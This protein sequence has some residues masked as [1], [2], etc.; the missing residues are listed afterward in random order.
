VIEDLIKTPLFRK[1]FPPV[2]GLIFVAVFVSLGLWQLDRAAQK[3]ALLALFDGGAPYARVSDYGSL[4]RFDRIEVSGHYLT[5]RQILIDNIVQ[6]GRQGYFVITP[7][8]PDSGQPLLLVNRGWTGKVAGAPPMIDVGQESRTLRGL[9]GQ[10]PRVGIRPGEAFA[11]ADEWPGVAVYPSRAEVSAQ[12]GEALLPVVLLLA[13]D[14]N[15]G[16]L[17]HWQPDQ[18][19]PMTHYGYAFQWFAMATAIIVLLFVH[20]GKR[21][22]RDQ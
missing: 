20:L 2:A 18:S 17:R 19:G 11:G 12:L 13:A 10:L 4:T 8:Q 3:N 9:V 14:E 21:R 22:R 16:Y 1:Y 7:F 6:S 15:D 5:N